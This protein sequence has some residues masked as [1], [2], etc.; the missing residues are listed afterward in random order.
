M[1]AVTAPGGPWDAG[2]GSG[3]PGQAH[4]PFSPPQALARRAGAGAG[5]GA[6]L[7]AALRQKRTRDNRSIRATA[8]ARTYD[9]ATS[10]SRLPRQRGPSC[11]SRRGGPRTLTAECWSRGA[12]LPVSAFDCAA[13]ARLT[14]AGAGPWPQKGR[15]LWAQTRPVLFP[16]VTT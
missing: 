1:C 10:E 12:G 4:C 14:Q 13:Q 16:S 9:T 11:R 15:V 8:R 5:R 3:H 2:P 7:R 6:A